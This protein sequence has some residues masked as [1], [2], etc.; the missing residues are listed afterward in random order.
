MYC[1]KLFYMNDA[2]IL[3]KKLNIVKNKVLCNKFIFHKS[4]YEL[5]LYSLLSTDMKYFSTAFYRWCNWSY[6]E[7]RDTSI[8]KTT[9]EVFLIHLSCWY[10]I[11]QCY[12]MG[13]ASPSAYTTFFLQV[14]VFSIIPVWWCHYITWRL[15][16]WDAYGNVEE[17]LN[18]R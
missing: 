16:H 4:A 8:H 10:L 2:S 3:N 14:K 13:P 5:C 11:P 17:S 6:T 15:I 18:H 1:I 9:S 12:L 7:S